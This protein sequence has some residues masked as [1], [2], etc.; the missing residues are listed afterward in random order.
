MESVK[1][2]RTFGSPAG[3]PGSQ[4]SLVS[5]LLGAKAMQA[6][7]LTEIHQ[8]L[9][10]DTIRVGLPGETKE[11]VLNNLIDLLK[12]QPGVRDLE[13]VREAVFTREAVMSTGVGKGLALPHAKTDAVDRTVAALAVTAHPVDFG[14]ID[15][16]PVRILFLL[17]GA[18]EAKTQHI[19][20]LSRISRL[21]NRDD[22]RKRLLQARDADEVLA[23]ME[24]GELSL[25]DG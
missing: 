8:L 6:I 16:Q 3:F 25:L 15:D 14:A 24:E 18:E 10:R 11:E 20:I 17:V 1:G 12:G 5:A 21:M 23:L 4:S 2:E 7:G 22:F 19:K 9:K 13:K